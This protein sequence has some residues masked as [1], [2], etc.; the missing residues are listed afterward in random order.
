[1]R[2]IMDSRA[3][4]SDGLLQ[5]LDNPNIREL[6]ESEMTR[7]TDQYT[8]SCR[9]FDDHRLKGQLQLLSKL[10]GSL[11]HVGYR[12]PEDAEQIIR[13][14]LLLGLRGESMRTDRTNEGEQLTF[15]AFLRYGKSVAAFAPDR[16]AGYA[17]VKR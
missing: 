12:R 7:T 3:H 11:R 14:R 5:S 8:C 15:A 6:R 1:M 17:E 13:G 4:A 16:T 10:S 9:R 2:E